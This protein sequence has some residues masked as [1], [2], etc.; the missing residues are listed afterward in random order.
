MPDIVFKTR[1]E[2]PEGLREHAEEKE[3]AFV[4]DAAPGKKLKEFRDNNIAVVKERDTYKNKAAE[5]AA[6]FG[7]DIPKTTAELAELRTIKQK[8]DDNKLQG[9]DKI[10]ATV[11]ARAKVIEDGYKGQITEAQQKLANI[12]AKN[13]DLAL[14]YKRSVLRQEITAV[15]MAGDS[16]ANPEALTDI[17]ACAE[18]D[19]AVNDDGKPVRMNGEAVV[20]GADGVTAMTPREW[21][22][23]LLKSKTYFQKPSVGGGASGGRSTG[24]FGMS[25]KDFQALPPAERMRLDR[26]ARAR[27]G[28][29]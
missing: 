11:A 24:N 5:Y 19:F 6:A 7:E 3:G 27:A 4:L 14:K 8:V 22:A 26:E 2:I 15:A 20:Y 21:L 23:G 25:D 10:E 18:T 13:A 16:G 17:L 12:T 9:T 28:G 1:E 29:R